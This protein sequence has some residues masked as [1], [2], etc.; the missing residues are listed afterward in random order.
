MVMLIYLISTSGK[1]VMFNNAFFGIEFV[2][3]K[4]FGVL[5]NTHSLVSQ[6]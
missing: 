4:G 1:Q 3:C 2:D 5:I 6:S